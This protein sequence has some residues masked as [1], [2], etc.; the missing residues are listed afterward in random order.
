MRQPFA[1]EF[2]AKRSN[3]IEQAQKSARSSARYEVPADGAQGAGIAQEAILEPLEDYV[4]GVD[5]KC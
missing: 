5:R 2:W 4:C 1:L 3:A